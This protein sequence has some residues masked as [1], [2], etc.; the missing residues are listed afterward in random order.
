MFRQSRK[1]ASRK[2]MG[3]VEKS[4]E[5]RIQSLLYKFSGCHRKLT[6]QV[7]E[8]KQETIQEKIFM[9]LSWSILDTKSTIQNINNWQIGHHHNQKI[10]SLK[11]LV[12]DKKICHREK[13][14]IIHISEKVLLSRIYREL[15]KLSNMKT[16]N[17]VKIQAKD[18]NGHFFKEETQMAK[19][20][21]KRCP[22]SSVNGEMKWELTTE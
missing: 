11:D 2:C 6:N 7:K 20:H 22:T 15:S 4:K 17:W 5:S 18:L 13:I 10:S 8:V 19:K 16:S 12:G 9:N 21:V 14:F 1:N 3:K